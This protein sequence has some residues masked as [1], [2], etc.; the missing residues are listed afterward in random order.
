MEQHLEGRSEA[1]KDSAEALRC[2]LERQQH[3]S[4]TIDEA[5]EIGESLVEFFEA[6]GSESADSNGY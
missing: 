4:I 2:I 1:K 5:L 6:L 3:K